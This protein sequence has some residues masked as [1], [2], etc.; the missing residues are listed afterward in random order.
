[1]ALKKDD[2]SEQ[3]HAEIRRNYATYR[4]YNHKYIL[5]NMIGHPKLGFYLIKDFIKR[6]L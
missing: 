5:R 3:Y 6:R 2:N 1:M 4:K